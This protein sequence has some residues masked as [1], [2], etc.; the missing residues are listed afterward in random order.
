LGTG[1]AL[2]NEVLLLVLAGAGGIFGRVNTYEDLINV[3]SYRMRLL[4]VDYARAVKRQRNPPPNQRVAFEKAERKQAQGLVNVEDV[5]SVH[6]LLHRL[7]KV[8]PAGA[9]AVELRFFLGLTNEE[10]AHTMGLEYH[11]FRRLLAGANAFMESLVPTRR[12][13][14]IRQDA[15]ARNRH[16]HAQESQKRTT[17]RA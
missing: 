15:V 14:V 16:S 2:V 1:S 8:D 4:L 5:L 7:E 6:E 10:A 3:L 12:T 11:A 9:K 13:T 17:Q